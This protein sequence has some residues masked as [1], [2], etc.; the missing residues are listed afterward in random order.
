MIELKALEP[1]AAGGNR[2]CY[3]DPADAARCIKVRRPD[4]SI[5]ERRR[6]KGFPKNLKPLSS[7]DDNLDE[8]RVMTAL[9]RYYDDGI[10]AHIS[11]CYGYVDTDMG[12]GLSSELIR[13]NNGAVS[14]SLKQYLWEKDYDSQ[15]QAAVATLCQHWLEYLVPS[16]DLILHNLVV[17]CDTDGEGRERIRRLVLIDGVGNAGLLPGHRTPAFMQRRKVQRKIDNLH[18]RIAELLD[19]KAQG[20]GPGMHGFLFHNGTSA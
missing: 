5:E 6:S 1:F 11:R 13:D 20:R 12:K 14:L 18:Q 9:E 7:F 3:I 10:F 16:R 4:F 2:W 15:C 8:F 19:D 17:Q